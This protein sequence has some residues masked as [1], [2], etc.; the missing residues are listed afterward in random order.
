[1]LEDFTNSH[2]ISYHELVY[3]EKEN[4]QKGM[5]FRTGDRPS[6]FLMSTNANAPYADTWDF[7]NNTLVYEGHDAYGF[8]D[9]KKNMDQPMYTVHGKL[10]DNGKFFVEAER[11]VTNK[12][13]APL[14]IQVYEKVKAGI[15][16]DKGSFDLIHAYIEKAM[17]RNVFKFV[18]RPTVN[19]TKQNIQNDYNHERMI[20][21]H[22]KIT[23]WKRDAGVCTTCGAK[24]GLHFDH[25]IPF[26]KGGRSDDAKNIQLLCARHNLMKSDHII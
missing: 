4:L 18:L 11:F 20:P 24:D 12:R 16:Y 23:V 1:M 21:S 13:P 26:S 19:N 9:Q 3:R 5:N 2:I 22:V 14:Q 15:W 8:G 6:V 10:T 17:N 7:A 25:I